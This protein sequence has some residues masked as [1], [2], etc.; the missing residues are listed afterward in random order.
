VRADQPGRQSSPRFFRGK[1]PRIAM[2][3][4]TC[5]SCGAERPD[6]SAA[7]PVITPCS[8]CGSTAVT[9]QLS[10]V[11]AATSSASAVLDVGLADLGWGWRRHWEDIETGLTELLAPPTEIRSPD[12][13]RSARDRLF[14]YYCR[15]LHLEDALIAEAGTTGVSVTTVRNAVDNEPDLALAADLCNLGKHVTLTRRTRSGVAPTVSALMGFGNSAGG[16]R[17]GLQIDHG[18]TQREGLQ[19]ASAAVDAW[20]RVLTGWRLI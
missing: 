15:V 11:M 5:T 8:S 7:G 12:A 6:D 10:A 18:G 13:I 9:V 20:R 4:V 1:Y 16:W 14:A 19:I 2:S 3:R 17:L